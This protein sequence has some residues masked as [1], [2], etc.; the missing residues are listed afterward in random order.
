MRMFDGSLFR[1]GW[2]V[3]RGGFGRAGLG[4][5]VVV[6]GWPCFLVTAAGAAAPSSV[7][8]STWVTNGPVL[9]VLAV[10]DRVYIGGEFTYVGPNTGSGVPLGLRS[11]S[12]VASFPK[13]NGSVLSV[14]SDRAGG[15]YVG[16][17]F[18]KV[19]GVARANL[20]PIEAN[21]S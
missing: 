14:V 12:P 17:S 4:V 9:S 1:F 16:G 11:G 6:L 15:Y 3:R 5:V 18:D 20:A 8:S 7:A 13:V 21:G 2:G 10:G 19:G